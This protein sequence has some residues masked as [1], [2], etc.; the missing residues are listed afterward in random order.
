M[1]IRSQAPIIQGEQ[2]PTVSSLGEEVG[3]LFSVEAQAGMI[4]SMSRMYSLDVAE[5]GTRQS[6]QS[7]AR[8]GYI[9][10]ANKA[11]DSPML[12]AASAT[13]RVKDAGLE[14]HLTIPATGMRQRTVDILID[15]KRE[16]LKRNTILEQSPGGAGRMSARV[17]AGFVGSLVDPSNIALAFVPVVGE[18]RYAALLARAGGM[19]SRTVVRGSVGAA[20]GVVGAA[21]VEPLNYYANTQQQAD[22]D[23]YDSMTNV[24]GG[25]FFGSALHAGAGL[26][27]DMLRPGQW[28]NLS[29]KEAATARQQ[30]LVLD[31]LAE[32]EPP[33]GPDTNPAGQALRARLD[34]DPAQLMREYAA[35][36]E[37]KGGLVL[38]TDTARE[39]SPE[40]L[41]DRTRSA[42]V[43]EAASDTVK[44]IYAA[45]L[46][47]PTPEGFD[48]TVLFT[49]GGTGAGK[50]TAVNAAGDAFG[51]PEI[52]YDTNMSTLSSAVK[53]VEQALAAGRNVRIAYVYRDPV[54]ALTN[55]AI[56]R[57]QRQAEEFGTGRTVPLKEHAK[58]HLGVR[59]VMEALADRYRDDGR[60][61]IGAIDNSRGKGNSAIVDIDSLPRVEE[62]GLHERLQA[63]LDQARTAGL[64]E[65][66]YR[67]F[68]A[69][70]TGPGLV[71]GHG[72]RAKPSDERAQVAH[73]VENDPFRA[74]RSYLADLPPDVQQGALRMA[75]AQMAAGR[76]IDVIP[77]LLS[78]HGDVQGAIAAATRNATE[79]AGADHYV[80]QAADL[81]LQA[82]PKGGEVEARTEAANEAEAAF[83]EQAKQSGIDDA[84]DLLEEG[85]Q[86]MRDAAAYTKALNIAALCALRT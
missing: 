66:L 73:A 11:P 74:I 57:A 7:V 38:N 61:V 46:A 4:G 40:Y 25:A 55:G 20:E 42:D 82:A 78:H 75:I 48:N 39:L 80:A 16:E 31:R 52:V 72:R 44:M 27:G 53:K 86:A 10:T 8:F 84:D 28:A 35:L 43:H 37:S 83:R 65:D 85:Q 77:A 49:A 21:L 33:L 71:A 30:A 14:G 24:A 9:D 6:S 76:P 41:A 12:T 69:D 19:A 59:P 23:A 17:A 13:Q 54:E 34:R 3:A 56:K 60:V 70:E 15:R 45:K 50:T 64:S 81:R 58:T 18:A 22:Y 26:F 1:P 62:T 79:V 63:A 36:E 2:I 51:K 47:E 67:G 5:E 68:A 32:G 29:P